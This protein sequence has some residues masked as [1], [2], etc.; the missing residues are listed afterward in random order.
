MSIKLFLLFI[1]AFKGAFRTAP[2]DFFKSPK[3]IFRRGWLYIPILSKYMPLYFLIQSHSPGYIVANYIFFKLKTTSKFFL[4]WLTARY[5]YQTHALHTDIVQGL[6]PF[7]YDVTA[8]FIIF[9]PL[10]PPCH[11]VSLFLNP[12][13]DVWVLHTNVTGGKKSHISIRTSHCA[14]W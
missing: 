4:I 3:P 5:I 6:G 13:F 7:T 8:F 12:L 10:L 14:S 1:T 9:D 11:Y 2:F